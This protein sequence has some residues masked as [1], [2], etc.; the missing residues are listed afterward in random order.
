VAKAF[1]QNIE[2]KK[3]CLRDKKKRENAP[4]TF[5]SILQVESL[6]NASEPYCKQPHFWTHKSC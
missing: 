4:T 1:L 5:L 6:Q 2:V 3:V